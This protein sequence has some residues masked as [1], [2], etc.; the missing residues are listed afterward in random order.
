MVLNPT[1]DGSE[2]WRFPYSDKGQRG[3]SMHP[4]VK[5]ARVAAAIYL[6]MV[7]TGPFSLLYVAG[8]LIVHG[9]AIATAANFLA[10]ET[11]FRF[12]VIADMVN[13]V[14]VLCLAISLYR[15]FSGVNKTQTWLLVSF[16]LVSSAVGFANVLNKIA[17]LIL[18]RGETS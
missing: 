14:I 4:T 17:A 10:H 2:I 15:L 6:S 13:S 1:K 11:L 18:F 12:G 16:V 7:V 8:N 5:A 9:D 3:Q